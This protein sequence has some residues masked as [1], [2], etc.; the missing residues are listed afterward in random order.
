M[1]DP[2]IIQVVESPPISGSEDF[3]YFS[4]AVPGVFL[5]AGCRP[6]NAEQVY[7]NHH[8]KFDIDEDSLLVAAKAM[9]QL[10]CAYF[11]INE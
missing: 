10:V 5:F 8:P 3:S 6:K 2:D 4:Q 9:A 1:N 7:S 11:Q